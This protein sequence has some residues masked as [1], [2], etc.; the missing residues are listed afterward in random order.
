MLIVAHKSYIRNMK[1]KA[2][3]ERDALHTICACLSH[4][5]TLH[6]DFHKIASTKL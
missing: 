6:H 1:M 3:Y 4:E 5:S 2:I